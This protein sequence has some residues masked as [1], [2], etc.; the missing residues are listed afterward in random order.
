[1]CAMA[2][3]VIAVWNAVHKI[4]EYDNA[5]IRRGEICRRR[6]TGIKYGNADALSGEGNAVGIQMNRRFCF[7]HINHPSYRRIS[8]EKL[9]EQMKNSA[10]RK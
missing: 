9:A 1:M 5:V 6:K 3:V 4:M 10:E 2:V 8:A 7:I